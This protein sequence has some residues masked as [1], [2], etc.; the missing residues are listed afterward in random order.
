MTLSILV[1]LMAQFGTHST[2]TSPTFT[3]YIRRDATNHRLMVSLNNGA[4]FPLD[5][6]HGFVPTDSL[7]CPEW[8]DRLPILTR[9]PRIELPEPNGL[10]AVETFGF[11]T[12]PP[13]RGWG[14]AGPT[15]VP[16]IHVTYTHQQIVAKCGLYATDIFRRFCEQDMHNVYHCKDSSRILLTD[17]SGG[18]HCIK[19]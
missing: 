6:P 8:L 4:E 19:F 10:V 5:C 12:V 11:S 7:D 17:E 3:D 14:G 16:A 9:H 13:V 1:L 2:G 15:D 18:K